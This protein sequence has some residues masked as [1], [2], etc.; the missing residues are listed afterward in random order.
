MLL[1]D[2]LDPNLMIM[3]LQAD[4][5]QSAITELCQLAK[6]EKVTNNVQLLQTKI[7]Q[8]EHEVSTGIGHGIA[9]PHAQGDFINKTC[10]LIAKSKRGV[11]FNAVDQQPVYL[12]FML[13]APESTDQEH[14]SLLAN[15][16]RLLMNKDLREKIKQ[17]GNAAAIVQLFRE[18][19]QN[20]PLKNV[21]VEDERPLVVGVTAC[22]NGISHTYMAEAALKQAGQRHGVRVRIETNGSEGVRHRLT[23]QEI[24]A[25]SG[26]IVAADKQVSMKRFAGKKLINTSTVAAIT[27]ANILFDQLE[28][29]PIFHPSTNH[30]ES[31]NQQV[32]ST[33]IFAKI[34]RQILNGVSYLLPFAIASGI[35][36]AFA[37]LCTDYHLPKLTSFFQLVGKLTIKF[38]IP[39]LSAYIAEAIAQRPAL[40][41][42]F[43][44]GCLCQLPLANQNSAGILGG[45]CAGLTAGGIILLLQKMFKPLPVAIHGLKPMIVFPVLGLLI[46][47]VVVYFVIAPIFG[48]LNYWTLSLLESLPRWCLTILTTCLSFMMAADLGGPFNKTAYLLSVA[49][50]VNAPYLKIAAILMAAVMVGDMVPPLATAW[51]SLCLKKQLDPDLM[52]EGRLN[53][54]RGV[55][56]IT[57]GAIPF[58][59]KNRAATILASV[60]GAAVSGFLIGYWQVGVPAPHGGLWIAVLATDWRGYLLST[61][62]GMLIAGLV[63]IFSWKKLSTD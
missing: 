49:V 45:L 57:E 52:R 9:M 56:F 51:A 37:Q 15:L 40:L 3:D 14:L 25:A 31:N 39:I 17:A 2:I 53:W 32:T 19:E 36:L 59:Q 44:G 58:A 60:I 29:A 16:S 47:A 35:F 1:T 4:N 7:W 30:K 34:W 38:M 48:Q 20:K 27:K 11:D 55:S 33:N 26:V 61:F 21:P 12:F 46:E 43:I 54:L 24:E 5:A 63:L 18:T 23:T 8:R 22:L 28:S 10:V 6:K 42:G 13:L 62:C 50:F 41:L